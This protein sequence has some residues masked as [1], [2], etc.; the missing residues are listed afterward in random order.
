[1]CSLQAVYKQAH[2]NSLHEARDRTLCMPGALYSRQLMKVMLPHAPIPSSTLRSSTLLSPR[3][4]TLHPHPPMSFSPS[5]SA[6]TFH[7]LPRGL[8]P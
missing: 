2:S 8:W 1:M 6:V 5:A 3:S 7:R 4:S